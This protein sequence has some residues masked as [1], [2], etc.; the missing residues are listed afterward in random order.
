MEAFKLKSAVNGLSPW[1]HELPIQVVHA[2][3]NRRI[4]TVNCPTEVAISGHIVS[5]FGLF[6]HLQTADFYST[7]GE[8]LLTQ[9]QSELRL[10]EIVEFPTIER[11]FPFNFPR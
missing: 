7:E 11:V 3:S 5:P 9:N 10:Q 1:V 4:R 2:H 6:R 8:P